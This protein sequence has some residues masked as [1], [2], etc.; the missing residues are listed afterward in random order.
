MQ[1]PNS[2]FHPVVRRVVLRTPDAARLTVFYEKALGLVPR[3]VSEAAAETNLVHPSSG[4]VLVTLVEDPA[5]RPSPAGSPG[6]FHTAFLYQDLDGWIS[7][8]GRAAGH[9]GG[10]TGASD[11][12]VSWAVYFADPD[13]NGIELAWDKPTSEWPWNGDRIQMTSLPLPLKS[14]LT[15]P[16]KSSSGTGAFRIGHLHLQV[17]DLKVAGYFSE[18]LDVRV[19]QSDYPGALFMARG[20]YHHHFAINTWR[21]HPKAVR[22]ENAAGLA[23][24]ETQRSDGSTF[25]IDYPNLP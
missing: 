12:G 16:L 9:L 24:W 3:R 25:V 19:T 23:G 6:L 22:A 13:G 11:H 17:A 7:A 5:A 14:I 20:N 4:E 21:T 1:N 2:H 15:K 18:L 8:L 10:L